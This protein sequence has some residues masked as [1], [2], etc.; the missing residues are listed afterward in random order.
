MPDAQQD[1]D[2]RWM[3]E[4]LSAAVEALERDEVPIGACVVMDDRI[5]AVAG[6]RTRTDC[7]PIWQLQVD[8]CG[9]L[10]DH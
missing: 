1:L 3:R 6:N 9:R 4:A 5:L 8:R 7:D 2:A 10:L